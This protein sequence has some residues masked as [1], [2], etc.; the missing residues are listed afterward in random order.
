MFGTSPRHAAPT[1]A[2][3]SSVDIT[4]VRTPACHYCVDAQQALT[5]LAVTFP[6]QVRVVELESPE[7]VRLTQQHRPA[8]NP[9]VLVGGAFFS[10]GRLPRKKLTA[11]L[12]RTT[13]HLPPIGT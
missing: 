12:E 13:V 11:L 7:G 3:A 8:M 10:A 1:S 2:L 5:D 6:L 4:V 9:L